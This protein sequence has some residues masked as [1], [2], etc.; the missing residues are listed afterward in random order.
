MDCRIKTKS[1]NVIVRTYY[2]GIGFYMTSV[3]T[4]ERRVASA[5]SLF[6]GAAIDKHWEM[7]KKYLPDEEKK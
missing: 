4:E 3:H 5:I 1:G 6:E 2:G 7:C